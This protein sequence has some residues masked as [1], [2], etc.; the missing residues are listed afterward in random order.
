M[1]E[2]DAQ[3]AADR[4]SQIGRKLRDLAAILPLLG[5]ILFASPLIS[6]ITGGDDGVLPSA[7]FYVF[8]VWGALIA[9]AFILSRFLQDEAGPE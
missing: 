8:A 1:E 6:A 5:V 2:E 3:S 4:R 7:A 9:L